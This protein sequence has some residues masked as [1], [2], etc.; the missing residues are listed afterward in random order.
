MPLLFYGSSLIGRVAQL[1]GL[2]LAGLSV[3][4]LVLMLTCLK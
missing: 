2:W 3:W 1:H 4:D